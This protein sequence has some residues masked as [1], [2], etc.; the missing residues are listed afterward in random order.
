MNGFEMSTEMESSANSARFSMSAPLPLHLLPYLP[1]PSN[2]V[3]GLS[4]P[5]LEF[6]RGR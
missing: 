1:L 3:G 6:A 4:V 2:G 5:V